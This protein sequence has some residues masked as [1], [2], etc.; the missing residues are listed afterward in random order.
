MSS[1]ILFGASIV[2]SL[3]SRA[4]RVRR[5]H[6]RKESECNEAGSQHNT[7]PR[8]RVGRVVEPAVS[9]RHIV[10]VYLSDPAET[11]RCTVE[12]DG[13]TVAK[14]WSRYLSVDGV[15]S[16]RCG[17]TVINNCGRNIVFCWIHPEGK[18]FH[19]RPIPSADVTAKPRTDA[20]DHTSRAAAGLATSSGGNTHTELTAA[21]HSFVLLWERSPFC[22][23]MD[24]LKPEVCVSTRLYQRCI[25]IIIEM[26]MCVLYACVCAYIIHFQDV[27]CVVR[28]EAPGRDYFLSL[29]LA[30]STSWGPGSIIISCRSTERHVEVV[31]SVDKVYSAAVMHGFKVR[32]EPGVFDRHEGFRHTLDQDLKEVCNYISKTTSY[33]YLRS[34]KGL[35]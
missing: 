18:L 25:M 23:S 12:A 14:H 32:I 3:I 19:F 20:N 24:Q 4:Y 13:E 27:V 9:T 33:Y 6:D 21:M 29:D 22:E 31:S 5:T 11:V 17:L 34:D 7:T 28:P 15:S 10:S 8:I 35:S 26:Y 1:S 2:G 16:D 30:A